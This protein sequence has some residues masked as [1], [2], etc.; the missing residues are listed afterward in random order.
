MKWAIVFLACGNGQ[1]ANLPC[2]ETRA[3][4]MPV[5]AT[6]EDCAAGLADFKAGFLAAYRRSVMPHLAEPNYACK[7]NKPTD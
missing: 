5:F 1:A 3:P 2:Q 4:N 7:P 6:Q